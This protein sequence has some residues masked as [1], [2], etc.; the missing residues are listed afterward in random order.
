MEDGLTYVQGLNLILGVFLYT[1]PELDAFTAFSILTRDHCHLYCDAQLTGAYQGVD[2]RSLSCFNRF[3]NL[4]SCLP[5][6]FPLWIRSFQNICSG[7]RWSPLHTPCQVRLTLSIL[8]VRSRDNLSN[9]SFV[10]I[11][12]IYTIILA[13]MSFNA[14]SPPYTE[15]LRLWDVAVAMGFHLHVI[16]TVARM[17]LMRKELIASDEYILS[18]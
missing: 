4:P 16:F 5:P 13:I 6:C 10:T 18:L 1:M 8:C 15:L 17:L 9:I 11:S 14:N 3:L 7:S 2:V 12:A